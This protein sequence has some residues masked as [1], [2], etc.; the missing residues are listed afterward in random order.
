MTIQRLHEFA[1]L[2]N[3]VFLRGRWVSPN[4]DGWAHL[5][6]VRPALTLL[7]AAFCRLAGRGL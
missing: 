1:P 5:Y 7:P 6:A 4:N 2:R 3:F